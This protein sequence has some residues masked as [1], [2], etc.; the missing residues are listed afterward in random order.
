MK[1]SLGHSVQRNTTKLAAQIR[2][3]ISKSTLAQNEF[4]GGEKNQ[5]FK[6]AD[7]P[8][9]LEED[10]KTGYS[11]QTF[12]GGCLTLFLNL[13]LGGYFV[14]R[15]FIVYQF[16]EHQYNS[17]QVFYSNE[18]MDEYVISIG[19]FDNSFNFIFGLTGNETEKG[20]IDILNNPFVRFETHVRSGGRIF[21]DVIDEEDGSDVFELEKCS[22]EHLSRFIL[23]HALEWYA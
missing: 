6:Y 23:E 3:K 1:N 16:N 4:E 10:L 13:L 20:D 12:F 2:K 14:W 5:T 18:K 19:D 11:S 21:Y 17:N 9:D 7:N 22:D 15:L 8:D